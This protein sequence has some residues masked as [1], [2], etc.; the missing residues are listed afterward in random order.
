MLKTVRVDFKDKDVSIYNKLVTNRGMK[1]N[2]ISI[3]EPCECSQLALK[4]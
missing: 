2:T 1:Q 3:E 4:S